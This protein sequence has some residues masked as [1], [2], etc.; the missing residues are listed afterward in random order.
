MLDIRQ[1]YVG[2]PENPARPAETWPARMVAVLAGAAHDQPLQHYGHANFDEAVDGLW[3]EQN[4]REASL[5]CRGILTA[6][7][8]MSRGVLARDADRDL[9]MPRLRK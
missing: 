8:I 6:S 9:T 4:R 7:P 2:A 3:R 5:F 1:Y